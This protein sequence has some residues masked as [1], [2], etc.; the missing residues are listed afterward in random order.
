MQYGNNST[1][2]EANDRVVEWGGEFIS[3]EHTAISNLAHQLG[4]QLE[5]A[6]E[7]SVGDE[8]TCFIGGQLYNE[9][10]LLDEWVG[11][12]YDITK[13]ALKDAP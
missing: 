1:V 11:G 10:N 6:N 8:E 7:L 2:Y 12:L 13:Q 3:S 4:L 9:H 5:D